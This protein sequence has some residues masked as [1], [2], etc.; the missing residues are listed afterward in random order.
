MICTAP[1]RPSA[2]PAQAVASSCLAKLLVITMGKELH[3]LSVLD[4][5]GPNVFFGLASCL[6]PGDFAPLAMLD[7]E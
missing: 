7:L 1:L 6:L 4:L 5:G 3:L 2:M